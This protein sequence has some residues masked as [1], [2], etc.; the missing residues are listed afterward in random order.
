MA[1]L[2]HSSGVLPVHMHTSIRPGSV[3]SCTREPSIVQ[4]DGSDE[5]TSATVTRSGRHRE[6]FSPT[7]AAKELLLL[8]YLRAWYKQGLGLS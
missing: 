6:L 7:V 2:T 3:C 5:A 4:R 1:G 8:R